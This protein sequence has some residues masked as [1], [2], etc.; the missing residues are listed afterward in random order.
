[1][2][3]LSF[4]A[5]ATKSPFLIGILQIVDKTTILLFEP[6]LILHTHRN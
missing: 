3:S 5:L 2:L 6:L 4:V 1:M